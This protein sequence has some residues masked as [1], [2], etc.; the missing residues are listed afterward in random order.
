MG[1]HVPTILTEGSGHKNF[2]D[3]HRPFFV[4]LF[5][6]LIHADRF[7][8]GRAYYGSTENLNFVDEKGVAQH[9]SVDPDELGTIGLYTAKAKSSDVTENKIRA[10]H[11]LGAREAV[12]YP[13]E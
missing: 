1:A 11:G 9:E 10:E 5:H 4:G 8:Q 3:A 12:N 13:P 2:I 7:E 6:E